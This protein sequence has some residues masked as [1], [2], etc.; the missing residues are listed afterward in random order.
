MLGF[1]HR[2]LALVFALSILAALA[3]AAHAGPYEDALA[4]FLT[5]D[6]DDTTQGINGVAASGNPLAPAVLGA[7]QDGRLLFS[8]Q[9]QDGLSSGQI[10][11]ADRR[12]HRPAGRPPARPPISLRC[13]INNRLRRV[14]E[15]ALGALTLMVGDAG[16]AARSRP[17]GVPV[18]RRDRVAG[19]R[20]GHRQGDRPARQAGARRGARRRRAQPR[21]RLRR[22]Q[23]RRHR[24]DPQPRRPGRG[25]AAGEPAGEQ[26]ARP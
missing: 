13:E 25:G 4:R 15:A 19:A 26:L 9:R 7:L 22:R 1:C 12:R 18:A 21:R 17:G 23:D 3:T 10:R 16:Q 6:F 20:A 14:I 24:G 11:P 8:A 5:D 2:L